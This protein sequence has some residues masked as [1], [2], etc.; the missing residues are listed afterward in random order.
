MGIQVVKGQTNDHNE[1]V[2]FLYTVCK[3]LRD[4]QMPLEVL[5]RDFCA[6]SNGV[7]NGHISTIPK[8]EYGTAPQSMEMGSL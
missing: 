7:C 1:A 6:T 5:C 8:E 4:D 3:I 2:T